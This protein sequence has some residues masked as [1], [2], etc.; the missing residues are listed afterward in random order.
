MEQTINSGQGSLTNPLP[1]AAAARSQPLPY[2]TQKAKEA[3]EAKVRSL[4]EQPERQPALVE[5]AVREPASQAP[6]RDDLFESVLF[7]YNQYTIKNEYLDRFRRQA[8]WLRE[9][10]Q[11]TLLIEGY[12]D[13]R[14][15]QD[16][17][18]SLGN[19][20]AEAIKGFL[21]KLGVDASRIQTK[22]YGEEN[23]VDRGHSEAAWS[24]NRRVRFVLNTVG[25]SM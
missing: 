24:Q 6:P 4:I 14:G 18:L 3:W 10:G 12:C 21:V 20:R 9:H 16:Y 22:T 13:E 19:K 2:T 15:S 11:D 7:D 17:N 1:A 5:E 25:T 23:P 8:D